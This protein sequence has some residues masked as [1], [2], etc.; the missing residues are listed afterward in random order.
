M[1]GVN[2]NRCTAEALEAIVKYDVQGVTCSIDGASQ[3]SYRRYR[4]NGDFDRVM[5]NIDVINA[6]KKRLGKSTPI[7]WWQFI[8]MGHNEQEIDKARRM[9]AERGVHFGAKLT[10]DDDFSPLRN[11]ET[12]RKALGHAPT[13]DSWGKEQGKIYAEDTCLQLWMKPQI[14]WDGKLLGCCFN[15]WG[16]FGGNA[17]EQGLERILDS[18]KLADARRLLQGHGP[19]PP[20]YQH[21]VCDVQHIPPTTQVGSLDRQATPNGRATETDAGVEPPPKDTSVAQCGASDP[22]FAA[23]VPMTDFRPGGERPRQVPH[24][25]RLAVHIPDLTTGG[26]QRVTLN[27]AAA[28]TALGYRVDLVLCK[29]TGPFL[30]QV[31]EAVTV[32]ELRRSPLF[33]ASLFAVAPRSLLP[34]LELYVQRPRPSLPN[35][36]YLQALTQYLRRARPHALLSAM[37]M[38]NLLAI[39]AAR[40]ADV[41]T[42]VVISEHTPLSLEVLNHGWGPLVPTL[43]RTYPQADIRVACSD[44]VADDLS[45]VI[46]IPRREVVT[47]YN[48]MVPAGLSEQAKAAL[49]HAWFHPDAPPVI[50]G[51]GRLTQQ[52]DFPTLLRAFARVRR[53]RPVRLIIL[54]EGPLR[55]DLENIV[56]TLGIVTDVALPGFVDNP[57]A[58]M[59][60]AAVF[61]LSSAWEG[62]PCVVVEALAAGCPVVSTDCPGGQAEIL[63]GGAYGRRVPV[64]DSTA[65]AAALSAT[66]DAPPSRDRLQRRAQTFSADRLVDRYLEVLFP[67]PP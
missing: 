30:A 20:G 55:A 38:P 46:R 44:G 12:L 52:K 33:P 49:D 66:L 40:L 54:G 37:T 11:F 65:L 25:A 53:Q 13:R 6:H 21:S 24:R 7:L 18:E 31:P 17:F 63:A 42:R 29:A 56:R 3:E 9:A 58:Y 60:R 62:I 28:L 36:F 26:V 47:I 61:A 43:R 2:L 4:V 39:W 1:N 35:L 22:A 48:S 23:A 32:V 50:L 34:L 41:S 59:A 16:D 51:A 67:E 8:V 10:W 15:F 19:H 45:R 5:A 14:N 64:G 27:L 57:F